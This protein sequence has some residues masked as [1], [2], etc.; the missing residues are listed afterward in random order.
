MKCE[1]CGKEI[2]VNV[3]YDESGN[4]I[5]TTEECECNYIVIN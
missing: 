5:E 1:K 2:I 3:V 4:W